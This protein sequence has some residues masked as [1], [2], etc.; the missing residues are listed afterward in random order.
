MSV[1][2]MKKLTVIS[3]AGDEDAILK[4]LIRLKCVEVRSAQSDD[5]GYMLDVLNCDADRSEIEKKISLLERV[6]PEL[7]KKTARKGKLGEKR[8]KI[9]RDEFIQS[10]RYDAAMESARSAADAMAKII[11]C[12]AQIK[13]AEAEQTS[14]FPWINHDIEA[15]LSGTAYTDIT[16]GSFPAGTLI[17]AIDESIGD[18]LGS[19]EIVSEDENGVYAVI[20][21]HKQDTE[22]VL[23][24]LTLLGFLRVVFKGINLSP[25]QAIEDI[26]TRKNELENELE[27]LEQTLR[28]CSDNLTDI[29]VLW[30]IERT[31]LVAAQSKQK[32]SKTDRCTV[33]SGWVPE[34]NCEK[35]SNALDRL[36]CAYD[37][38]DALE[39]EE[40][41][42]HLS[43]NGFASNFEWVVGMY[44]YP[45]YGSFDPT[46]IMSIFYFFIF[47]LMFADV[48]YGLLLTLG[49]FL[50][51]KIMG[52]KPNM[53][54]SF[55]MFGYCGIASILMGVVFGG[56]FGD[57]P[58]AI[59]ENFMG[60]T[61]ARE[62]VPFF[63]GIWFNP[64]DDP[65][66]F[67]IVSLAVGGV[68]LIAGMVVKFIILCKEGKVFDAI[69]DIGS[70]WVI[71]A[72]IGVLVLVGTMAG[73]I[74]IGVGVLMIV[75]THGR[76]EKKLVMK[77]GKGLL[78]L[79]D[80]TS[81]ASDLLSYSRIL[82]LGLAAAV[83]A[84]VINLIGTMAGPTVVGFI[85]LIIACIIGHG[86]NLAINVLGSFVHTS[87]LQYLEFFNKFY[88]DG[89]KEFEAMEPSEKYTI[90]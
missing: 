20:M 26:K 40:P 63:N 60:M 36:C 55:N 3:V 14:L 81:Y 49:G 77:I 83:I 59:M 87:R 41:P 79:Y 4:R 32:M 51:P 61:N 17:S 67:L 13:S 42:V 46:F 16:L 29:E 15:D 85:A 45:K 57:M 78:G 23:R 65:M 71:F 35:V 53:K 5:Y 56:W 86:L 89:G 82:A 11:D 90:D 84:Q 19:A 28:E 24:E 25:R 38:Y 9:N 66:M 52:L 70:W 72:G 1:S 2:V 68:H 44:S 18:M 69:F 62:A 80:I 33:L 27:V 12:K 6:I 34:E 73:A 50:G 8:L 7:V 21:T 75:L 43:N 37:I 48:G 22:S 76:H 10:G 47:G 64:I 30:D 74:T 54:R 88:E 58:Y 39:D 31:N